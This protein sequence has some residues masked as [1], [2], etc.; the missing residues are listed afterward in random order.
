MKFLD[1]TEIVCGLALTGKISPRHVNLSHLAKP[2]D[3]GMKVLAD[4]GTEMDVI[5]KLGLQ[6]YQACREAVSAVDPKLDWLTLLE[7]AYGREELASTFEKQTRLL[8]QGQDIEYSRIIGALNAQHDFGSRYVTLDKVDPED[9]IWRTSGFAPLDYHMGGLPDSQLTIIGAPPGTGKSSL[10]LEIASSLAKDKK[11]SLIYTFEMTTKQIL[12]R[13][14]QLKELSSDERSYITV[15]EEMLTIDEVYADACR[16]ASLNKYELIA[17]DF[18]DLMI[19]G[20]VD[21]AMMGQIYVLCEVMAKITRT[22]VVLISQLNREYVGGLPHT[23]NI[24]WSGMAESC[25]ALILLLYNPKATFTDYGKSEKLPI[26]EGKGYI[27]VGKS[28]FG[29]K[30]GGVGA[31]ML[32]WN[33]E[34]AWGRESLGWYPL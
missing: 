20:R 3:I 21:E 7:K 2:Y 25:A 29:Y 19:R 9:F 15:C 26:L 17:L 30:E 28:R 14:L 13:L 1:L 32:D 8:R 24:R 6:P 27:I 5:D 16:L 31:I 18:A 4:G 12:Y 23:H 11:K 34:E 33:G 10:M 22:P